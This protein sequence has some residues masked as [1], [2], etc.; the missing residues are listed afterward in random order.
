M[1]QAASQDMSA[2]A[3]P[4]GGSVDEP[5][6]PCVMDSIKGTISSTSANGP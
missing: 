1:G 4:N 6:P 3:R 2:A 5:T